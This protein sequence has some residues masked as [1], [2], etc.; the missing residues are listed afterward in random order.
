[1]EP[2]DRVRLRTECEFT[3][4]PITGYTYLIEVA[5]G[6]I[7]GWDPDDPNSPANATP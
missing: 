7:V 2:G 3:V 6:R 4:D 5:T 1:M